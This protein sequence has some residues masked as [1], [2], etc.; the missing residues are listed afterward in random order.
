VAQALE[1]K[2]LALLDKIDT[3]LVVISEAA[4][5]KLDMLV[6]DAREK[7]ASI[8]VAPLA[9]RPLPQSYP[10][11]VVT[12]LTKEMKLYEIES[13]GPIF[14]IHSVE[15]E[16]DIVE[17]IQD[18]KYGLSSSIISKDYYRA[19][20]MARSIKAGAVHINSMTVHDEPTLPHG[21]YGESGWGRFG[22]QWGLEE[23]VQTK[24]VTIHPGSLPK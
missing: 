6:E 12:G 3:A 15:S 9:S 7:G 19:L 2:L 23:F 16:D 14:G 20:D 18:A 21:G 8:H 22:A 5:E 1:S 13:F 17:I 10:P 4:K 24:V 11:T